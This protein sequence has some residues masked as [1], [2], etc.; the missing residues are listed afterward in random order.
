[1]VLKLFLILNLR[2]WRWYLKLCD[3]SGGGEKEWVGW[4]GEVFWRRR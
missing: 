2:V 4:L 1:M 3:K